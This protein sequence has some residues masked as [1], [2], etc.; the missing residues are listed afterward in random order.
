ML[1]TKFAALWMS[2]SAVSVLLAMRPT[3]NA[4][5][6]Q[7]LRG[8]SDCI[9]IQWYVAFHTVVNFNNHIFSGIFHVSLNVVS[10]TTHIHL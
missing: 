10:G 2:Q 5:K 8:D 1:L 4:F 6:R 3:V 9:L 7:L